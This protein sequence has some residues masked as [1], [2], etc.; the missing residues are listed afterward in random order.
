MPP[1][2]QGLQPSFVGYPP[3]AQHLSPR[4]AGLRNMLG[5]HTIRVQE[6][7]ILHT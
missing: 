2:T 5:V 7:G 6:D 4:K 1:S 3:W